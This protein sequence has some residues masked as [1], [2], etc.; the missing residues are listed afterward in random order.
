MHFS[1]LTTLVAFLFLSFLLAGC[2]T[3][4]PTPKDT[5]A[6]PTSAATAT[7]VEPQATPTETAVPPQTLVMCLQDEPTSLYIYGNNSRSMWSVLEAVYDG[8]FDTRDYSIQPVILSKI[9]SLNDGDAVLKPVAVKAGDNIVDVDGNLVALKSGTRVLP[10]G[11]SRL[12]CAVTWDG[13]SELSMDQLVV[14]F[15]LL[16]GLMWSD[17]S[18]A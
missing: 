2:R 4:G 5:P 12:D 13:T 10:A 1:K 7:V 14:N 9:P 16:P 18:P 6:A 8:P 15:K 17:G 11:C 3:N